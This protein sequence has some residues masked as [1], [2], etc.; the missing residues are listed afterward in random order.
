MEKW[1]PGAVPEKTWNYYGKSMRKQEALRGQSEV[2]APCLL[3]FKRFRRIMEFNEK[4]R[5]H[6]ITNHPKSRPWASLGSIFEIL[7]GFWE[8]LVL[9]EILICKKFA[10]RCPNL[11]LC[12]FGWFGW[13]SASPGAVLILTGIEDMIYIEI[14]IYIY[15]YIYIRLSKRPRYEMLYGWGHVISTLKLS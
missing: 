15:I 1:R 11:C 7:G 13:V 5:P 6:V 10:A 2:F 14:Y 12:V 8:R 9:N 3:Q 4:W